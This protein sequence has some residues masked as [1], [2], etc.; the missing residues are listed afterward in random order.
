MEVN[1]ISLTRKQTFI[2][3]LPEQTSISLLVFLDLVEL[4]LLDV[5][6]IIRDRVG[7]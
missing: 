4:F 6:W 5:E 7:G 3:I 1:F 2:T